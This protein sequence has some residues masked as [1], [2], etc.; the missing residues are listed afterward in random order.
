MLFLEESRQYYVYPSW[1][2]LTY[3]WRDLARLLRDPLNSSY[4]LNDPNC[5]RYDWQELGFPPN[6]QPFDLIDG[7]EEGG[8][9]RAHIRPRE[10]WLPGLILSREANVRTPPGMMGLWPG[11]DSRVYYL[12]PMDEPGWQFGVGK[13]KKL[14][15]C[16]SS[17]EH[18]QGAGE[19]VYWLI[20]FKPG[21]RPIKDLDSIGTWAAQFDLRVH[22]LP[23]VPF[24][25]EQ[26]STLL[27]DADFRWMWFRIEG[28]GDAVGYHFAV[29]VYL[30]LHLRK[31]A[32]PRM[33][34]M[35]LVADIE[36]KPN[37]RKN[38]SR[39]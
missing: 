32:G 10:R 3:Q 21:R 33:Q 19:A 39:K 24:L 36:G 13:K 25:A 22:Q 14:Y 15:L 17:T 26:T 29:V 18:L 4:F 35:H 16:S 11:Y 5:Q 1:A 38:W 30:A 23:G 12:E 31:V 2:E 7:P 37:A 8:I 28:G 20:G 9:I 34:C 6:V 27:L